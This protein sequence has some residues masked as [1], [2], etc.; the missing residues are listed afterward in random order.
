MTTN[1]LNC[2]RNRGGS[3]CLQEACGSGFPSEIKLP[4]TV[5]APATISHFWTQT[6]EYS[7]NFECSSAKILKALSANTHS[8]TLPFY[9]QIPACFLVMT[10]WFVCLDFEVP[11]QKRWKS[12]KDTPREKINFKCGKLQLFLVFILKRGPRIVGALC[13]QIKSFAKLTPKFG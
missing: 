8:S 7:N 1:L 13:I 3:A 6:T 4:W 2:S 11:A 5:K 12:N 9:P 10:V